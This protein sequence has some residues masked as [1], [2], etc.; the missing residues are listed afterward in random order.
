MAAVTVFM[1]VY[2]ALPYLPEAVESICR[3]TLEDWVFL[4]IDDGSTDGSTE[5]LQQLNDLRIRVLRQ[6]HQGPAAASQWALELCQSELIAR[7]DADDIAHPTR[8]EE[9]LR[10]LDEHREVGLL[11]TQIRPIG[12]KRAG[13]PSSLP[14][15]HATIF[16]DLIR[17]RHAICN[18][19]VMCRASRL[20][21]AGGYQADGV[22]EDWS[23]FL[24]MGEKA[25]LANLDRVLLSY[26]IHSGA[27]NN[28]HM[29]ELRTRIAFACDRARRRQTRVPPIN[30]DEFLAARR[31]APLWSRIVHILEGYAMTEYR[32]AQAEYLGE[33]RL[34]GYIR[35]AWAAFCSPPLTFQ[36]IF[37]VARKRL[38][39]PRRDQYRTSG[40][41]EPGEVPI[42]ATG[43]KWPPK[44]DLF[45]VQI[46]ATN[47]DEVTARI[48]QAIGQQIPAIVSLQ[49]VHAV[50]TASGDPALRNAVN[51][52]Q[53]VAPDGQPVRWAMN[54]LHGSGL[55]ERVYGPELML[56]ICRRAAD[57]GVPVY[58]YGSSF[59]VLGALRAN[60]TAK[61]PALIIAGA[62]SPPFRA[63]TVQEEQD[64]AGRIN[65]SGAGIVFIG[66][67]APKQDLFAHRI[68]GYLQAVQICV[69]AA[70]DFHAGSKKMAPVWMQRNGLE[71]LFRLCMEPRRLWSRYLVTNSMFLVK[72]TAALVRRAACRHGNKRQA[73]HSP[74]DPT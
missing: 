66:L 15:D 41:R 58:L 56:R 31:S 28:R 35:L 51:T 52:F 22:L 27:T 16:A 34:R 30:Y 23:M 60:L 3:Q 69:G 70:F 36:R 67:G 18:P 48:F 19:T 45:G 72:L 42:Q 44:Y 57:E 6:P 2:N 5:Y 62:E 9:Q 64:A 14:T 49:A 47:Y 8:L 54:L 74:P 7:M 59:E 26:R 11:G 32:L 71:W 39:A 53:I 65:R 12:S 4:I 46:S 13:R 55:R 38:I 33:H 24:S 73:T 68:R 20:R 61:Y 63:L 1:P 50:M 17:G 37:R 25:H 40:S 10:F 43:M 21:E 29:A